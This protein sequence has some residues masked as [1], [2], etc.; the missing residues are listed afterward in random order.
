VA[1]FTLLL[2][3]V[4]G[5]TVT[6]KRL[7]ALS[8]ALQGEDRRLSGDLERQVR[9]PLLAT[10]F[11]FRAMLSLGIVALMTIKPELST[12]FGI[13]SAAIVVAAG[14]STP[15]WTRARRVARA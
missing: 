4:V 6:R 5:A 10:S 11:V 15:F 3:A 1:F 14:L 8:Q 2:I 7:G 9:D 12:A 13:M